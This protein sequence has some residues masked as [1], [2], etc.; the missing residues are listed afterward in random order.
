MSD[1]APSTYTVL[2]LPPGSV[3][4]AKEGAAL[5]HVGILVGFPCDFLPYIPR[6]RRPAKLNQ[7]DPNCQYV[8]NKRNL[9]GNGVV[10]SPNSKVEGCVALE[11]L[12]LAFEKGAKACRFYGTRRTL[13]DTVKEAISYLL[14]PRGQ[15][16]YVLRGANCQDFIHLVATTDRTTGL[17]CDQ[18]DI[19]GKGA[20]V[21]KTAVVSLIGLV[22][23][24]ASYACVAVW[25]LSK[26]YRWARGVRTENQETTATAVPTFNDY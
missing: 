15:E 10:C 19:I 18:Q 16:N 9:R 2:D 11:P 21:P 17:V 23:P 4:R 8:V 20:L 6:D 13:R 1:T 26:F 7:L 22:S 14:E 3:I 24:V 12:P 5:I 25:A